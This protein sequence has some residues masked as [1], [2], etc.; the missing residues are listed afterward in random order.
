MNIFFVW[1]QR[2]IFMI[3]KAYRYYVLKIV[4]L[5]QLK[6]NKLKVYNY[7]KSENYGEI[8]STIVLKITKAWFC[9]FYVQSFK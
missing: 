3:C 1:K 7:I 4:V 8:L 2:L 9:I 5:F 6:R